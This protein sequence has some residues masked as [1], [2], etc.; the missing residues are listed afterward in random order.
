MEHEPSSAQTRQHTGSRL[1]LIFFIIVI[2]IYL[3]IVMILS[4]RDV[5]RVFAPGYGV[6]GDGAPAAVDHQSLVVATLQRHGIAVVIRVGVPYQ[7]V[8]VVHGHL[9]AVASHGGQGESGGAHLVVGAVEGHHR[10]IAYAVAAYQTLEGYLIA[11]AGHHH[12]A[13]RRIGDEIGD[14]LDNQVQGHIT[15]AHGE[16]GVHL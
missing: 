9:H 2:D 6:H 11:E 7:F 12:P 3:F 15:G 10:R 1:L 14:V 13:R 4:H 16:R 8:M 5:L